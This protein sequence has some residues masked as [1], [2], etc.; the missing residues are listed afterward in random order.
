M[1]TGGQYGFEKPLGALMG[2]RRV[3][4]REGSEDKRDTIFVPGNVCSRSILPLD[5]YG[6]SLSKVSFNIFSL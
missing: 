3:S 2:I 4:L 6:R 1:T 5:V